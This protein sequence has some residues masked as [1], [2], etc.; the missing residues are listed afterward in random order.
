MDL[1][2]DI[3][4]GGPWWPETLFG[5]MVVVSLLLSKSRLGWPLKWAET[6]Y[7]EFSHGMACLVSGGKIARIELEF[8]GAGCCYTRGGS[9]ILILLMGYTGASLWGG[10]LYM[11]GWL[12]G[13]EGV[14]TW[15]KIE[16]VILA[17]VF[18]FW[19]RDW[20]TWVILLFISG[21]YLLAILQVS[22]VWL[23]LFLQFSGI[24][25][26]LNA[27]RAPLHL[28]DGKDVGDGA[29]LAD[30]LILPEGVWITLWLVI[31]FA[32]MG[33]CMVATLP[34]VNAW[35]TPYMLRYIGWTV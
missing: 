3:N 13:S 20:R 16:L 2:P 11:A 26:M 25:V 30:I 24:Y 7:H 5:V 23:P 31:A 18:V 21:T 29:D 19:A 12:A 32:V 9:R 17:V 35:A 6:F 10:F 14:T 28:I 34:Q 4:M 8:N 1:L 33:A 27:L 22:G 15:L